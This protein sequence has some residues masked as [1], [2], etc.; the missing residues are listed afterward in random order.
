MTTLIKPAKDLTLF[1][2]AVVWDHFT[3]T[4][5]DSITYIPDPLDNQKMT[6]V[7]KSHAC[8][9]LQSAKLL[10]ESQLSKYDKYN[11]T[12]NKAAHTYCLHCCQQC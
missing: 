3:D 9:N 5:M 6:K 2:N 11:Y 8:Y 1:Q 12:N 4:G 7:V 10:V